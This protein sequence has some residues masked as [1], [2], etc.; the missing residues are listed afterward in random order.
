MTTVRRTTP[1]PGVITLELH[2]PERLNAL[3][4]DLVA[5]LHTALDEVAADDDGVAMDRPAEPIA[6][7]RAS[8]P[9]H[10]A[11]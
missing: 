1:R 3:N 9:I 6:S 7:R 4:F 11:A 10:K 5:D 2:R 8:A